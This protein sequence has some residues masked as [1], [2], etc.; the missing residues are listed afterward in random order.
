MNATNSGARCLRLIR[1]DRDLDPANCIYKRRLANVG[2]T[3]KG[4]KSATHSYRV[5][6]NPTSS[7]KKNSH[8]ELQSP[9]FRW[10]PILVARPDTL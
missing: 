5:V 4:H 1:N 6:T 10:S 2:S 3:N 9:M 7:A 8:H